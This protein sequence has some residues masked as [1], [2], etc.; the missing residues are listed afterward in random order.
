MFS[1]PGRRTAI[2]WR[3]Q[4][5]AQIAIGTA[6]LVAFSLLTTLFVASRLITNRSLA[7]ATDSLRAAQSAFHHLI[8]SRAEF[9]ATRAQLITMS[10]VFR[11]H[12]TDPRL[13]GDHATMGAMGDDFRSR[14][15]A[16]FLVVTDR[17]GAPKA[18]S[19]WPD[20]LGL[21]ALQPAIASA[22][23]HRP[24]RALVAVNGRLSVVVSEPAL[25]DQEVLGTLTLG[26]ELDDAVARELAD[27]THSDVNLIVNHRLAASSF[28]AA[29]R[30]QVT[31]TLLDWAPPSP[32]WVALT[33]HATR[34]EYVAGAFQVAPDGSLDGTARL[35]LFQDWAPTQRV[36]DGLRMRLF[37][38]G[39]IVFGLA[40]AGGFMMGGRVGRPLDE[41]AEA[42]AAIATGDWGRQVPVRGVGE[43]AAMATAFNAM[44][45]ELQRTCASLQERTDRLESEILERRRTEARSDRRQ[46]GRR[47][48]Q[49]RE[50]RVFGQHEPRTADAA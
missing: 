29:Q 36:L 43:A 1:R 2:P 17:G 30:A 18:T 31:G 28:P 6:S 9:F 15:A 47:T 46:A 22:L 20:S 21:V 8:D 13:L 32:E 16:G 45:A 40:L 23:A 44:G 37:I 49:R 33:D 24:T 11:A 27:V 10:P 19:G 50:E 12:L 35:L 39:L 7:S 26:Y 42:A 34:S 3:H 5:R 25:F 14:V 4:L 38:V 41:V 48:G